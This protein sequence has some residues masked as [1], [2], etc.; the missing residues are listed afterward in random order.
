MSEFMKMG[1]SDRYFYY[2][3]TGRSTLNERVILSF[4]EDFDLDIMKKSADEALKL[5]PEYNKRIIIYNGRPEAVKGTGNIAFIPDVED[6]I[7]RLGSDETNGLLF[8]FRY[9]GKKLTF[10]TFHGL[11][12]AYGMK[13]FIKIMLYIYMK[14]KGIAVTPEEDEIIPDIIKARENY[15]EDDILAPYEKYGDSS[16]SYDFH[17]DSSE[18]FAILEKAYDEECNYVHLCNVEASVSDLKA[19]RNQFGKSYLPFLVDVVSQSVAKTF[20]SG[21]KPIVVMSAVDQRISFSSKSLANCSDS[22]FFPYTAELQKKDMKATYEELFSIMKQ[23][24]TSQTHRKMAGDKVL[25]VRELEKS[26]EGVISIAKK[27][28]KLPTADNFNPMTYILSFL[29]D[30]S[31]GKTADKLL[32]DVISFAYGRGG[33]FL[34]VSYFGDKMQLRLVNQN[35]SNAFAQGIAT[36]LLKRGINAKITEDR[37][38]YGDQLQYEAIEKI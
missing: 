20:N 5:I 4:K 14:K 13:F 31:M 10:S 24:L 16:L 25:A 38:L 18:I 30:Q 3:M 9:K 23:Q 35:D 12:D 29:G 34:L 8:F 1:A 2:T 7:V 37:K 36:E 32:D 15:D 33:K 22:I 28:E 19:V 17:Y 21:D 11:T 6:K 27:L 26:S